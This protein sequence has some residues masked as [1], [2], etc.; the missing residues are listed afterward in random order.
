MYTFML[1]LDPTPPGSIIIILHTNSSLHLT[2][3]TPTLMDSAPDIRYHVTYQSDGGEMLTL[4][5]AVNKTELTE[6]SSGTLYN[7]TLET[8][9]PQNLTSSAV[10]SSAFTRKFPLVLIT[11]L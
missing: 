8:V 5:T 9:G 10:H 3:A 6:L 11:F 2:W 7:I 1:F 4:S